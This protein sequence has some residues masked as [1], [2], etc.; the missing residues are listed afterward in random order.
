MLIIVACWRFT[1]ARRPNDKLAISSEMLIWSHPNSG[2]LR[3]SMD[4]IFLSFRFYFDS[5]FFTRFFF[6]IVFPF[7]ND[8]QSMTSVRCTL[9]FQLQI[10][11]KYK[12]K[13]QVWVQVFA[14]SK[15][16]SRII[17]WIEAHRNQGFGEWGIE[18]SCRREFRE[19]EINN[20]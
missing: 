19:A 3:A 15:R 7:L 8:C 18:G 9:R 16:A 5:C 11:N 2:R 17:L 4:A 12:S 14:L 20:A 10:N 1:K 13:L 6:K